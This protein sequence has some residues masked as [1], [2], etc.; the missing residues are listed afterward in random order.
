M[1]CDL[2]ETYHIL[3]YK[4]LPPSLVATLVVGLNNDSRVKRKLSKNNIT[5]EQSLLALIVDGVITLVWQNTKDGAKNR[6]HPES[7]FN[8]LTKANEKP[9]DDLESFESVDDFNA[10]Y[11]SKRKK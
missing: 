5:L 10:W 8:R 6:N 7:V 3:D 9:S 11:M 2:A 1:I 4:G